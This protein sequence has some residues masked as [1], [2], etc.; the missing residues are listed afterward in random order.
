MLQAS[1]AHNVMCLLASGSNS[2]GQLGTGDVIDSHTFA[3]CTFQ[4]S[5]QYTTPPSFSVHDIAA[6]GRHT[7]I[8]LRHHAGNHSEL[9]G[10]GDA[11]RGQLGPQRTESTTVLRPIELPSEVVQGCH[12]RLIA[13]SW[14]TSYV[15]LSCAG[16]NDILLS[17]G[18]DDFGNLGRAPRTT[19]TEGDQTP[20]VH[21]VNFD[22]VL[23]KGTARFVVASLSAG[24]YHVVVH[25]EA[26]LADGSIRYLTVGW[27]LSRHGQLGQASVFP[28]V[29]G[30]LE[31]PR[32]VALDRA[33]DDPIH[34]ISLGNHHSVFLRG[35]GC[36]S[37][38]GSSKKHQLRGIDDQKDVRALG[39]TW[40]G[41]YL[42]AGHGDDFRILSAGSHS[43]GQLGRMAS[44]DLS[45]APVHFP[46]D[47]GTRRF[48]SMACGSE[49][50]LVLFDVVSS[51]GAHDAEREVWGWGWNE[52]GNL[53]LGT[54]DDVALPRRIWPDTFG[55][56]S[57]RGTVV[58]I[59]AGCG[60]SWIAIERA[61]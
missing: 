34:S 60:T 9:W 52:H 30:V 31:G 4:E 56:S 16:R 22:H 18:A 40:N 10:C 46:F 11:S 23:P 47:L 19:E 59:W 12:Y 33:D 53:G 26:T 24:L 21:R 45:F 20:G 36:A 35:S 17:M 32:P 57:I 48:V 61:S 50:V 29:P 51:Q 14:E 42:V 39:C 2:V 6:G 1:S 7:L 55:A 44:D 8:L 5:S 58:G 3:P 43:K 38:L 54:T 27:G 49:H 15:V 13:C 41:T 28:G 25:L 37:G